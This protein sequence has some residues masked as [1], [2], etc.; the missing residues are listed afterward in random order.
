MEV[1]TREGGEKKASSKHARR[2]AQKYSRSGIA[3]FSNLEYQR[4]MQKRRAA[5]LD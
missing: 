4:R 3:D 2:F 1:S 5:S